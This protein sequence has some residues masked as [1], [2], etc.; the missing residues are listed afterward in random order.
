MPPNQTLTPAQ[1]P[2]SLSV[3]GTGGVVPRVGELMQDVLPTS[4]DRLSRG[5]IVL[6]LGLGV[7]SYGEYSVF[8]EPTVDDRARAAALDARE[9]WFQLVRV[10]FGRITQNS[11]PSGS[12]STVHVSSP[13]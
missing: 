12:A 2:E 11:L 5:R 7:D 1:L 3:D 8:D 9:L 4:L 13:R 6:G 10:F